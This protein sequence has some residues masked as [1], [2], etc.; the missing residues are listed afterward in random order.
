MKALPDKSVDLFICDLPYGCLTNQSGESKGFARPSHKG[1]NLERKLGVLSATGCAWDI[2]INLAAFWEQVERTMKSDSTPIIMFCTV[3]FGM[4]LY[5]S[6]PE[7]FRYDL[8]W[9]K[10]NAV[11]FLHANKMPLRAHE[12]IFVFAKKCPNFNRIPVKVPGA[13]AQKGRGKTANYLTLEGVE[14]TGESKEGERCMRSVLKFGGAKGKGKHPTEK[15][16]ELY[17]FLIERYSNK[18]DTV[19]DPTAGSFNA[20]EAA[21]D[22]DR[23][24]IGIEMNKTFYDRAVDRLDLHDL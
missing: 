8:V 21:Y 3:R 19:L 2:K 1:T 11:G 4:E 18:G 9:E 23:H 13:K 15:P 10:A 16:H 6:K 22:L 24:G 20:V 14:P 7:W 5:A 17:K 12:N